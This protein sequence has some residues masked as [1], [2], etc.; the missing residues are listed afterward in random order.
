MY[1]LVFCFCCHV[2]FLFCKTYLFL[3]YDTKKYKNMDAVKK[4]FCNYIFYTKIN[5]ADIELF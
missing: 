5:I 1:R 3:R 4:Y 2:G